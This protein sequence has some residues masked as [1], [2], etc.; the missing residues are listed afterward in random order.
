MA[1]HIGEPFMRLAQ[2]KGKGKGA[3][4]G[5]QAQHEPDPPREDVE[6]PSNMEVDLQVHDCTFESS[7]DFVAST[8][9]A[10]VTHVDRI[11]VSRGHVLPRA[12]FIK[13]DR[14]VCAVCLKLQR[15]AE[16]CAG[17]RCYTAPEVDQP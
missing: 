11:H 2:G 12:W 14:K 16:R 3:R 10:L 9:E 5:P 1:A 7:C 13:M 6:G 15:R 4:P 17:L 8:K